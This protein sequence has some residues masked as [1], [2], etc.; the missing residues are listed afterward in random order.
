MRRGARRDSATTR[1]SF[2]PRWAKPSRKFRGKKKTATATAAKPSA[3]CWNS[4]IHRA[5]RFRRSCRGARRGGL[6]PPLIASSK[7]R[8]PASLE[9]GFSH[10]GQIS[11]SENAG[12]MT[13]EVFQPQRMLYSGGDA[14]GTEEAEVKEIRRR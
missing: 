5:S 9:A 1:F 11:A 12:Y 10:A 7:V 2:S 3:N 13:L 4:S 8:Y 6:L 14:R